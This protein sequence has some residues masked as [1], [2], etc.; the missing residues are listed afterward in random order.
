MK[1]SVT[2]LLK[3][4]ITRW[5]MLAA[6]AALVVWAWPV[7]A[8]EKQTVEGVGTYIGFNPGQ[9]RATPSGNLHI[10]GMEAEAVVVTDN[11]LLSGR[12][13]WVGIWNSDA[14]LNG[15]GSGNGVLEVGT[16]EFTTGGPVFT[17]S[18]TGGKWV[19]KWEM[20]GNL[21]GPYEGKVIMHGIAGEVDGM[22]YDSDVEGGGGFDYYTGQLLDPHAKK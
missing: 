3:G 17:P 8:G 19:T 6:A 11:P 21:N 16:W 18:P 1:E 14:E 4:R 7:N 20:K 2:G 22:Q 15:G 13:T 10:T 12:L 9:T 5:S